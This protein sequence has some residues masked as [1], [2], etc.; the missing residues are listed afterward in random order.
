MVLRVVATAASLV[1]AACVAAVLLVATTGRTGTGE[2]LAAAAIPQEET[3]RRLETAGLG[4]I[5]RHRSRFDIS[6]GSPSPADHGPGRACGRRGLRSIGRLA[7]LAVHTAPQRTSGECSLCCH[8]LLPAR[9]YRSYTATV[10]ELQRLVKQRPDL[11]KLWS[12]QE[13][14]GLQTAGVCEAMLTRASRGLRTLRTGY[15]HQPPARCAY[16]RRRAA[17]PRAV[18]ELGARG[19]RANPNPNPTRCEGTPCMNWV[20]EVT[21]HLFLLHNYSHAPRHGCSPG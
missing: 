3:A 15:A 1:A 16:L 8:A 7:A 13:R 21:D 12:T 17:C 10:T 5:F 9:R 2:P 4:G 6:A 20:L 14:Y 18:H 19:A 11:A